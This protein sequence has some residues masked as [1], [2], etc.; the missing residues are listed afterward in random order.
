LTRPACQSSLH[1][2]LLFAGSELA[3][4]KL[5]MDEKPSGERTIFFFVFVKQSDVD[6]IGFLVL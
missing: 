1:R 5:Y 3:W 6:I 2:P 4:L